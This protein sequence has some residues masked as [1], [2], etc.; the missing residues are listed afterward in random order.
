MNLSPN[1]SA[2][3]KCMH[4][5]L[6]YL[7]RTA[8]LKWVSLMIVG[9]NKYTSCCEVAPPFRYSTE[10]LFVVLCPLCRAP[11]A[12]LTGPCS[13]LRLTGVSMHEG[14][15]VRRGQLLL[16]LQ[17]MQMLGHHVLGCL[18]TPGDFIMMHDVQLTVQQHKPL[19][20]CISRRDALEGFIL[21][22]TL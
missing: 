13:G 20:I 16:L 10:T 17:G 22:T 15:L 1:M 9:H 2:R 21:N 4:E 3:N 14:H 11:G 8:L 19:H 18:H 6:D 7:P 5:G 12:H